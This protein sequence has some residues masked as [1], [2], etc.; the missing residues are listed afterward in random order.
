MEKFEFATAAGNFRFDAGDGGIGFFCASPSN[1]DG[2][3]LFVNDLAQCF[4]DARVSTSDDTDSPGLI[5]EVFFGEGRLGESKRLFQGAGHFRECA[6]KWMRDV[7]RDGAVLY[8]DSKG[9]ASKSRLNL[10][11]ATTES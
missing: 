2:P 6:M 7:H 5:G 10:D 3:I 8:H 4:A 11:E 1:V 9:D